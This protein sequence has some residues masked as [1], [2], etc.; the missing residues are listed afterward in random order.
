LDDLL[1][2]PQTGPGKADTEMVILTRA[3]P[4][5]AIL[6]L[7]VVLLL[8]ACAG[9]TPAPVS[10]APDTEFTLSAG[11]TA[12]I[13]GAGLTV[14][15]IGVANDER[16]P[17]QIECA[18][19][20]PVTLTISVQSGPDAPTEFTLQTFTSNDGRSPG[21]IFQGIQDRVEFGG[22]LI[23]VTGVLPYPTTLKD[24]N[25]LSGYSLSFVVTEA[26]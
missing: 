4:R 18:A 24:R 26:R 13:E 12:T 22:Y 25:K 16:C 8:T 20:G 7:F 21:G 10:A 5:L 23:R 3:L 11:Q 14:Q 6:F 9:G 1:F 15:L 17:S 2:P 19:S